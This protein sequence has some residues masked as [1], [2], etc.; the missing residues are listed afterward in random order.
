MSYGGAAIGAL[1]GVMFLFGDWSA[2]RIAAATI[3]RQASLIREA[4]K[5]AADA[6]KDAEAAQRDVERYKRRHEDLETYA[7]RLELGLMR[8]GASEELAKEHPAR[9]R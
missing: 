1:M 7:H 9:P 6:F 2:R 4:Q 8:H 3:E 5:V